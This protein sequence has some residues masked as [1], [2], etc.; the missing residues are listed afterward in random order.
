LQLL[1]QALELPFL[2]DYWDYQYKLSHKLDDYNDLILT[3]V[4]SIDD[5]SVN[6]PSDIDAQQQATLEQ[7]PVIK[8]RT[9]T[10][11]ISW[12]KRFKK[13]P[14]F[15]TTTIS[16]NYLQNEFTRFEDNVNQE[17]VLFNNYSEERETKL[18]YNYTRFIGPWTIAGGFSFQRVN[19]ANA[20]VDQ[21]NNFNFDTDLDFNRSG[22]FTQVSR[23]FLHERLGLSFGLRADGNNFTEEGNN[24]G[25]TLSPRF[26]AS[27]KLDEAQKWSLNGSIGRYYKIPPYTILGFQDNSGSFVNQD[28]NYIES[29]HF[30]LGIELLLNDAS[31]ISME[32]FYKRYSNYPVST[33]DSVSL[34]NLGAGFEVLGNEPIVSVG[35]G[36]TYGLEFLYQK[37]L[38][39]KSYAILAY[40]LFRSEFTAFD[41]E[42]YLRSA[43]D[44]R[45]LL[46][47]TGG[48]QIG[49]N[50]ELS[51]RVRFSGSTPFAPVDVAATNDQNTY[52]ILIID[53]SSFGEQELDAFNQTDIRID[54]KWNFPKWTFNVFF[55]VQNV[56]AQQ[57][58][59][60]PIYGLARDQQGMVI[61]PQKVEEVEE[62]AN[63]TPL[64]QI[65][66]VIDF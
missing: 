44:S 45:Q 29:D 43:W 51:G 1:F 48:Y 26:S 53:Y 52:P 55:E 62:I 64:P 24:I 18:R 35:L 25:S 13:T 12:K 41:S 39:K 5:F 58:P 4:G 54:K 36:R 37:K 59:E 10:I 46:T 22:L 61:E 49:R 50:W 65:G 32:G 34:A 57:I 60:P 21:T 11:G 19:Y 30:V 14:G 31:R 20:T 27:Y 23:D 2:P 7:V 42:E 17:G 16:T 28:V 63:S 47:F 40:T 15:M 3:G 33:S 56:F 6:V 9:N 38:S 66:I 8:Q